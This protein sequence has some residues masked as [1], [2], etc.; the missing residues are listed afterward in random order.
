MLNIYQKFSKG[1]GKINYTDE[2]FGR[3]EEEID[4]ILESIGTDDDLRNKCDRIIE[5]GFKCLT[6]KN[7]YYQ[8]KDSQLFNEGNVEKKKD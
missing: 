5:I 8:I 4:D 6:L 7:Y 3:G 2:L 1:T